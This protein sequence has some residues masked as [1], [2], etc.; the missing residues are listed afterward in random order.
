[1]PSAE[2]TEKQVKLDERL[3]VEK[4]FLEQLEGLGWTVI[5][6]ENQQV[7]SQTYRESF[8]EVV[9]LPILRNQLRVINMW[10][11]D[12]KV[13]EVIKQLT[14]NW[15]GTNLIKNNRHAFNL[16]LENTS[17]S[18]NRKTGEKSPT[19]RFIDYKH[20]DNHRFIA[21]CQFKVR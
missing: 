12:D 1:M 18:E 14:A 2:K 21:V 10:L 8:T 17:V 13:E 19:V 16:L 7:P 5:D 4:P 15:P 9:M 6:C 11:E 3:H 20:R